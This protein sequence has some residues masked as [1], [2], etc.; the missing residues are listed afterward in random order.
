[1]KSAF[2]RH[3][4]LLVCALLGLWFAP[5]VQAEDEAPDVLIKRLSVDV[6]GSAGPKQ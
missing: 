4:L 6:G 2:L 5:M 3:T 1:M